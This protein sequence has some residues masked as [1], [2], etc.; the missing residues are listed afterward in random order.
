MMEHRVV[1]DGGLKATATGFEIDIRLPW[2]RSVPLSVVQVREV[3]V[4]G[5]TIAPEKTIFEINNT[6]LSLDEL[7]SQTDNWWFVVDS[8]L[9]HVDHEPI[10]PGSTHEVSVTVSLR[11][12]YIPNFDRIV[13]TTKTLV[14]N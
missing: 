6:K 4:D 1:S 13:K 5:E 9:L 12:P 8:A 14:A 11:P 3:V 2:Y 10:E 7:A